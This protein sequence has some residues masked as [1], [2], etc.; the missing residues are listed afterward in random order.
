MAKTLMKKGADKSFMDGADM[1]PFD[2][3]A[4]NNN[5]ELV[6]ILQL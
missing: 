1:M 5:S 4:E 3:A 6:E 2:Y